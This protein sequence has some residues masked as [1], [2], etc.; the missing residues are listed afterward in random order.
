[1]ALAN[2]DQREHRAFEASGT[3]RITLYA[4]H[5]VVA[6]AEGSLLEISLARLRHGSGEVA[7]QLASP[8]RF[9]RGGG[10]ADSQRNLTGRLGN[11]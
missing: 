9:W 2:S 7:I 8:W 10:M 4:R 3:Q 5:F 11:P 6:S 1:M